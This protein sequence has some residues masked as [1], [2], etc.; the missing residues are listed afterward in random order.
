MQ[1]FIIPLLVIFA[2]NT[3]YKKISYL[4]LFGN[5]LLAFSGGARGLLVSILATG[6]LAY[7]LLSSWRYDLRRGAC[8]FLAAYLCYEFQH[9]FL[10]SVAT[11]SDVLRFHS[12][13]RFTIWQEV[14]FSLNYSHIFLGEGVGAYSFHDF[15]RIEGHPHNSILQFLYEWGVATFAGIASVVWIMR[16]AW[17]ELV[18]SSVAPKNS[19]IQAGLLL[20][21]V[22]ACVYSLFSGIVVMPVPQ[23]L[24]FLGLGLLW[25]GV[26]KGMGV[27]SYQVVI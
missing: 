16:R 3:S 2:A 12:S 19:S 26:V 4:L 25:G 6:I 20:A 9:L 8:V 7:W 24:L 10:D 13:G 18:Q 22:S 23:T 1:V 21:V 14:I 5:F 11:N 17:V 15:H 27:V